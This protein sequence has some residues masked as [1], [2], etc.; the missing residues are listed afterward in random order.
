[1]HCLF[2]ANKLAHAS[3]SNTD[4]E[5]STAVVSCI[6][7]SHVGP[8]E[9]QLSLWVDLVSVCKFSFNWLVLTT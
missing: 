1:M 4:T 9:I 5:Y 2:R 3:K 7:Q 8:S 6:S